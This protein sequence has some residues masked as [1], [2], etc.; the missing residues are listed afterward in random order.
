MSQT[1]FAIFSNFYCAVWR[2][3]SILLLHSPWSEN[4]GSYNKRDFSQFDAMHLLAEDGEMELSF[5]FCHLFMTLANVEYCSPYLISTMH[6]PG[7]L[8]LE[9]LTWINFPVALSFRYHAFFEFC[10]QFKWSKT[11]LRIKLLRLWIRTK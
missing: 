8:A 5:P 1:L 6:L 10:F 3:K 4:I 11:F 7:C 2:R 9:H